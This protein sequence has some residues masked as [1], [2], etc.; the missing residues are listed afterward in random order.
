[1]LTGFRARSSGL[2][3]PCRALVALLSAVLLTGC[4]SGKTLGNPF[5]SLFG[6]T[7][8]GKESGTFYAAVAGVTLYSKPKQ[9]SSA[10]GQLSLHQK[11]YRSKVESG[12]AYVKVEGT[13]K[14]GWVDNAKLLWRLPSNAPSASVPASSTAAEEPA[15]AEEP[16]AEPSAA[17]EQAPAAV[18]NI[19]AASGEGDKPSGADPSLFNPF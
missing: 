8:R 3:S 16:G 4:S 13:G 5:G 17:D 2:V 18:E 7:D 9:S 11:V 1:M 19:P 10:V 6:G 14:T 15:A 12:F